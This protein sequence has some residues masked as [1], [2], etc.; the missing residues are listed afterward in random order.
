[1]RLFVAVDP[2]AEAIEHLRDRLPKRAA[3]LRWTDPAQWHLTLTF[4]GEVDERTTERLSE[5]LTR[6]AARHQ[7]MTLRL[8]GAGAFARPARAH[9]LWVGMADD[10]D[11]LSKLAASTNAAARRAGID[12]ETRR[13]KPHL[14]IAR[15]S[16]PADLRDVV[17]AL[18]A[19]DGPEFTVDEMHLVK[20]TL[21]ATTVHE[22]IQT[23]RLG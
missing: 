11:A 15:A 21:G 9:A 10:T 17:T 6:A 19:Y 7:P 8:S 18:A 13:F 16:P 12:V 3:K 5:R 4:C 14:T 23:W 2:A 20:S 1:M 22:R